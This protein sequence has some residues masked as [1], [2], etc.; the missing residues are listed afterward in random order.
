MYDFAGAS[1][2]KVV[3]FECDWF[4]PYNGTRENQF[5]MTEV[6]HANKTRDVCQFVLAHQVDQ[7]YYM[8]YPCKD[9]KDWWVV[10]RVNPRERLHIVDAAACHKS[11]VE[12]GFDEIYQEDEA[13][14]SFQID[15]EMLQN[16]LVADREDLVLPPK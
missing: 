15:S 9:L 16:S 12:E 7:V 14:S 11:N 13:P 2:L 10:Y 8:S 6:K 5:G 3:F 1:N 4:D